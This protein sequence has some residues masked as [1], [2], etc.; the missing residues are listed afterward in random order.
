MNIVFPSQETKRET[1]SDQMTSSGT[2]ACLPTSHDLALALTNPRLTAIIILVNTA[3]PIA[4][5]RL[6]AGEV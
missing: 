3:S 1:T 5:F 2:T 6:R 4:R